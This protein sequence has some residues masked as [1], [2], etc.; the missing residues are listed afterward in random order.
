MTKVDRKN[1]FI[2]GIVSIVDFSYQIQPVK[3]SS[4]I[5][6]IYLQSNEISKKALIMTSQ[7]ISAAT[8]KNA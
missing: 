4:N 7:S 3:T 6:D 1:S 5:N 2:S 8:A